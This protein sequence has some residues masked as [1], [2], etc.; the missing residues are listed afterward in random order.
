MPPYVSNYLTSGCHW[1][2][3]ATHW[4]D[5]RQRCSWRRGGSESKQ[6]VDNCSCCPRLK[7]CQNTW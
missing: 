6:S 5:P 7:D 2:V 3:W 1:R 4:R